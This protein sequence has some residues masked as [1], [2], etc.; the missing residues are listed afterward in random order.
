MIN[1]QAIIAGYICLEVSPDS[2]TTPVED[3]KHILQAESTILQGKGITYAAGGVVS[4]VGLSLHR[5]GIPVTMIGKIG[6]D[7]NGNALQN[8][9][10]CELA[11]PENDL[12]IDLTLP[13]GVT[14]INPPNFSPSLIH[15]PGVN[16]TFYASDIPRRVLESGDL[17]HFGSPAL[18]RSI[19]R[20]D[21]AEMV[22]ILIKARKAGLSASLDVSMI[23]ETSEAGQINWVEFLAN[24]LPL[25]DIFTTNFENLLFL[26]DRSTYEQFYKNSDVNQEATPELLSKLAQ[27]VLNEGVKAIF[28][29]L[30]NR[31]I[32]LKTA[33]AE[34]WK[35]A[36]RALES[37]NNHWYDREIWAPSFKSNVN[38]TTGVDEAA[39]AGF[40]ASILHEI[41]A[42]T[43]LQVAAAARALSLETQGSS[44]NLPPWGVLY[45][46]VQHGCE[47]LP[48]ELSAVGWKKHP[49]NGLWTKEESVN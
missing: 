7:Q 47:T 39:V 27:L 19:Y 42:E 10:A 43:A 9:L 15:H 4:N 21:G 35:K 41:D 23:E 37:L 14:L 1:K 2:S 8:I 44:R 17:F 48:L 40:I 22:S 20:C 6:N 34:R 45:E 38:S 49:S 3:F 26:L 32:Y 24:T 11:S 25:T 33:P 30:G 5:M 12:A 36:G 28:V 18:M 31:G 29:Q 46:H 13:T 16:N